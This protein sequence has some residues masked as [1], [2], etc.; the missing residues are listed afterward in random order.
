MNKFKILHKD[1]NARVGQLVTVHGIIETPNF[2]P[3][4]TKATV[5]AISPKDLHEIGIQVV[6][7]NTYHLML[8]PG[9]DLIQKMGG[10]HKFMSWDKPIMTDSGGF[11]VFSLGVGLQHG[12]GKVLNRVKSSKLK[13]QSERSKPRLNSIT[14]EEVI[15]KSHLDGTKYKLTPEKSMEIQY[16]LGADLIVAFDDHES[17]T[18]SKEQL[19]K[20]LDLTENW[21]L[22]S[23]SALKKLKS[24]QLMYGVVHGATNKDLRIKSAKFTDKYFDGVAIGG[25]YEDRKKL[26]QLINWVIPNISDEKPRHLLGIGEIDNL[27][28]GVE[29][30]LDLF[31]CTAP[32]RRARHGSLYLYPNMLLSIRYK[33]YALDKKPIDPKCLCYTCQNFSRAYLRFLFF[34]GELTFFQLATYHNL[35][36]INS[37]MDKIRLAIKNSQFKKLKFALEN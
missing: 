2:I 25:I 1:G 8:R 28:D 27:L 9:A 35:F 12:D 11:Q 6:L 15:F 18:Y 5:K 10:L 29:V 33:K 30:G 20:S 3:V 26:I 21:A 23:L 4:G 17:S 37:L 34:A 7:A 14:K 13:V 31:D 16:K 19:E 22:R 32:T 36:F 24:K